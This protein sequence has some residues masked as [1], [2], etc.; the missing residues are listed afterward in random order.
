MGNQSD[1]EKKKTSVANIGN[2]GEH[3]L[4]ILQIL[5]NKGILMNNFMPIC[6]TTKIK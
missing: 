5:K 1:E 3:S 2:K 6:S 4:Q